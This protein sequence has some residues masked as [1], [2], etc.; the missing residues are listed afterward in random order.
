M[1]RAEAYAAKVGYF[2]PPSFIPIGQAGVGLVVIDEAKSRPPPATPAPE[3][4]PEPFEGGRS[5]GRM[6]ARQH[7]RGRA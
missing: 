2:E 4:V 7:F 6:V 1:E 5:G 3:T